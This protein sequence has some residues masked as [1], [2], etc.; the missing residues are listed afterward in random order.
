MVS[1]NLFN[2]K[3]GRG[4]A[5][6]PADTVN[7]AGGAA[8]KLTDEAALVQYAVTGALGD[9]Y[10][11]TA[12]AQLDKVLELAGKVSPEFVG[13]T[14]VYARQ[15]GYMK[16]VPA[17]LVAYLSARDLAVF[18]KVFPV[19]IDDFKMLRNFVQVVRSGAV[20]RKSFGTSVKR[21]LQ[22]F[23]DDRTDDQIFRGSIG[24]DPALADIL[25]MIHPKPKTVARS[26]LYSYLLGKKFDADKLPLTAASF[27]KFKTNPNGAPPEINFQFLSN[28]KMS[29]DQWAQLAESMT[30]QTLRMNLNTLA[31]NGVFGKAG[32]DSVIANRLSDKTEISKA[33]VF[34]YQLLAAFVNVGDEVPQKVKN[35]LQDAMEIATRNVPAL[36]GKTVV[37]VDVSGSMQSPVTGYR[38]G[39]TSKVQC[40]DVA[41]LMASTVLRTNEDATILAFTTTVT[42]VDLNSRD[43]VMTNTAKIKNLPMGGTDAAAALRYVNE[44]N[45]KVDNLIM[46]S[47][48]ESWYRGG[49]Y[50]GRGTDLAQ[51]WKKVKDRCPNARMVCIDITPGTTCQVLDSKSMLNIG[52]FNDRVFDIVSAFFSHELGD[53]KIV[54][55]VKSIKL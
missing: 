41:G 30:W 53:A 33:K 43:S 26:N 25:K 15:H 48:S 27:E 6:P 36:P 24:N 39:A 38:A 13:Q 50:Y 2:T 31:R 42:K 11:V 22:K 44:R 18:K 9:T 1:K 52:G 55:V 28:I 46:I 51:E 19:V 37:C 47:D 17:V 20:G 21:S 14:A 16:D 23:F 7:N 12:E 35:A 29:T 45:M 54:D 3:T 4:T 8:Y 32:T 34:P 40:V 10:Y 49:S 5:V